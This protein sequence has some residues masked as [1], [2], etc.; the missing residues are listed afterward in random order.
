[1]LATL[2]RMADASAEEEINEPTGKFLRPQGDITRLK[3]LAS[4]VVS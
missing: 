1:L 2:S 3:L 4:A